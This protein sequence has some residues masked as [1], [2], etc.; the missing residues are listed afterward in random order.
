MSTTRTNSGRGESWSTEAVERLGLATDVVTA[1]K[2]LGIG[3]T[4]AYALA[5]ANR[6]PVKVIR[7]GRRY[8]VS[9]A[10]LLAVMGVDR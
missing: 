8:V 1:A 3:R 6:F 7:V 2:I 4:T 10:D 5:R 9:V